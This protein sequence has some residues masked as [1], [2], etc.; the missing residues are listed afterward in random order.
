[1]CWHT[2]GVPAHE[3]GAS[4]ALLYVPHITEREAVS[5]V[6]SMT[7]ERSFQMHVQMFSPS[8]DERAIA[9]SY[10]ASHYHS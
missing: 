1:M 3:W 8:F 2:L 7:S 9:L 4:I 5:L 10:V 6:I